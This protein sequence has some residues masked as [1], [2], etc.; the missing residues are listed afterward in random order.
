MN[1][2]IFWLERD[3][4]YQVL[5]KAYCALPRLISH[6]MNAKAGSCRPSLDRSKLD[7]KGHVKML[8][9]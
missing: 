9:N 8:F 3:K 6:D 2:K 5:G 1:P 4:K 7:L